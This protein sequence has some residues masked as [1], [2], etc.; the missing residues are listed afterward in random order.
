MHLAVVA[1]KNPWYASKRWDIQHSKIEPYEAK[2]FL[3]NFLPEYNSDMEP[4]GQAIAMPSS[5]I[6]KV[7]QIRYYQYHA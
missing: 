1:E 3:W 7:P 4:L 2:V 5:S 6:F